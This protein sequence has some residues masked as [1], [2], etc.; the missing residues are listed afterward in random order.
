MNLENKENLSNYQLLKRKPSV[1]STSLHFSKLITV[2]QFFS[3]VT[4][5]LQ[6]FKLNFGAGNFRGRRPGTSALRMLLRL[7]AV[8]LVPTRCQPRSQALSTLSPLVAGRKT[9]VAACHVTTCDINFSTGVESTNNLCRSQLKRNKVDRTG[10]YTF[11]D[12]EIVQSYSK[13]HRDQTKYIYIYP[14]Y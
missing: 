9:L 6:W 1:C 14:A 4:P 8:K 3:P 10:K 12:F 5:V 7:T 2:V 13:L 11:E